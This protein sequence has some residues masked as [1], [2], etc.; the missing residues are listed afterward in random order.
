VHDPALERCNPSLCRFDLRFDS[1][2][3]AQGAHGLPC[4]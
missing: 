4:G 2:R 3:F 1:G